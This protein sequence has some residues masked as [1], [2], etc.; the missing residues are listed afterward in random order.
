MC[1][2]PDGLFS[3]GFSTKLPVHLSLH[4]QHCIYHYVTDDDVIG[5][6]CSCGITFVTV[7][8]IFILK[9]FYINFY[10]CKGFRHIY[11]MYVVQ[12]CVCVLLWNPH[13]SISLD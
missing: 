4:L 12:F 5:E 8:Y 2:L 6:K 13:W 9:C 11:V 1:G 10:I 3:S 7:H